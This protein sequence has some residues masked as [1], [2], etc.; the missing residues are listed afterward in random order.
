VEDRVTHWG[1]NWA[2]VLK[3]GGDAND[4]NDSNINNNNI[5]NKNNKKSSR[6]FAPRQLGEKALEEKRREEMP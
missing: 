1:E 2:T 5:N 6:Y 4:V 3:R